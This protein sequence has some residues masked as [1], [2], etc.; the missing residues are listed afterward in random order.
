MEKGCV[1]LTVAAKKK[2]RATI[3]PFGVRGVPDVVENEG[4]PKVSTIQGPDL[5]IIH[6][7]FHSSVSYSPPTV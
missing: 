6:F 7:L 1:L 4:I 2:M 3:G 5:N